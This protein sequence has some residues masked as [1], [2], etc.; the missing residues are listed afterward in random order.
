ML[1]PPDSELL[2]AKGRRQS[3][4][5]QELVG[6]YI[7]YKHT[8]Q[9]RLI[10][11]RLLV[12]GTSRP[13]WPHTYGCGELHLPSQDILCT[14]RSIYPALV[15][16]EGRPST[17][18]GDELQPKPPVTLAPALFSQPRGNLPGP[19]S[20]V[21]GTYAPEFGCP[22]HSVRIRPYPPPS[23]WRLNLGTKWS[24]RLS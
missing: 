21:H 1:P 15:S 3:I 17:S 14:S 18:G 19:A 9:T 6:L 22:A 16:P 24:S 10:L 4:C 11:P 13:T 7:L 5:C 8:V 23:C 12:C 2:T 20:H